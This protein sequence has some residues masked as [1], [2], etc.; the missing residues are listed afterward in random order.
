MATKR[1]HVFVSGDVQGVGFRWYCREQAMGHDLRGWVRNLPDRQVEAVFEGA[2]DAVDAL[3][4]WC[5][6][7]PTGANVERVEV[8]DESPKGEQGFRIT[9]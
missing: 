8:K 4:E 3:V 5:R 6:H 2:S 7:G 1:V 9:R